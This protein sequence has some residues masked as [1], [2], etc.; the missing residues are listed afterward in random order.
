M[1]NNYAIELLHR[2]PLKMIPVVAQDENL[3]IVLWHFKRR[4]YSKRLARF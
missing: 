1:I 3:K 2:E 4:N